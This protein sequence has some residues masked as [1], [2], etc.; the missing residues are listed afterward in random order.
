[1]DAA[2]LA[3]LMELFETI[4]EDMTKELMKTDKEYNVEFYSDIITNLSEILDDLECC[5]PEADI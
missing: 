3:D 2:K 5:I 4:R 1:M